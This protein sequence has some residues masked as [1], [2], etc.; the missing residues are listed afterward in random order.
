[1]AVFTSYHHLL[2][3]LALA[4]LVSHAEVLCGTIGS[5]Q[6]AVR[7]QKQPAASEIFSKERKERKHYAVRRFMQRSSRCSCFP[8]G[9]RAH[10]ANL[11]RFKLPDES[12]Q[13]GLLAL[14][15]PCGRANDGW[16][17]ERKNHQANQTQHRSHRQH[18]LPWLQDLQQCLRQGT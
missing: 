9:K 8:N 14:A 12:V 16:M 13:C 7:T 10:P 17:K 5:V 15:G 3:L 18:S 2:L 6:T 4:T 1:M 11:I